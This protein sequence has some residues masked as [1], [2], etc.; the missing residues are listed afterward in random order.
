MAVG[1]TVVADVYV[2]DA[3][4]DAGEVLARRIAVTLAAA[5]FPAGLGRVTVSVPAASGQVTRLTFVRDGDGFAEDITLRDLHPMVADRLHLWRLAEFS[6]RR[7]PAPDDVYL[8][9]ATARGN[10]DDRRL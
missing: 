7:L 4:P 2:R 6:L 9:E 10:P 5:A 8:F 1:P 3:S